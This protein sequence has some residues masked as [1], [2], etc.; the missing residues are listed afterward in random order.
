MSWE[1]YRRI[2]GLHDTG[3]LDGALALIAASGSELTDIRSYIACLEASCHAQKGDAGRA[4]RILEEQ[5]QGRTDNFW[6]YYAIAEQYRNLGRR[7]DAVNAYRTA[8]AVQGW[9]ESKAK[10]Y[11]FTHDFFSANIPIWLRWFEEHIV[12]APIRC[13]E[14]G[15]WQGTSATWLLDKIVSKRQGLITCID[16]FEGS[17][18][19]QSWLG[20]LGASI[21]QFFDQNINA[22]GHAHLCRKLVGRSQDILLDLSDQSYDFVYIDG[23]HEAKFVIQDAILS[24]RILRS[25]G[26]LIFDDVDHHIPSAPEQDTGKAIN[27]FTTWFASELAIVE[28]NRQMLIRKL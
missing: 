13:L 18:E 9:P 3:D 23:A 8:H 21:Q 4:V 15:S 16:T 22:S 5:V 14:I 10:G 7:D 24:W 2:R 20:T 12:M 27:A 17:S 6:V 11:V 28:T 26:F 19:H 1:L 25:G